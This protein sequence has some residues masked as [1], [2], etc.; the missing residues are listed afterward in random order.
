M[1]FIDRL[2]QRVE[3]PRDKGIRNQCLLLDPRLAKFMLSMLTISA[4]RSFYTETLF[5]D[6]RDAKVPLHYKHNPAA[7]WVMSCERNL[8]FK[9]N[10]VTRRCAAA[11][12]T[13]ATIISLN[14]YICNRLEVLENTRQEML[15]TV[16]REFFQSGGSGE[17]TDQPIRAND[18]LSAKSNIPLLLASAGLIADQELSK[19]FIEW[20]NTGD[21]VLPAG[22]TCLGLITGGEVSS[23]PVD[24][25]MFDAWFILSGPFGL[26]VTDMISEHLTFDRLTESILIY[27]GPHNFSSSTLA[28]LRHFPIARY[29]VTSN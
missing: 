7:D 13:V 11:A 15:D 9:V 20:C 4:Q 17:I 1:E 29:R 18:S 14:R 24:L 27:H 16:L 8:I 3:D 25:A 23:T 5:S 28:M 2:F 26:K 21:A 22:K 6:D 19:A 12:T 10:T